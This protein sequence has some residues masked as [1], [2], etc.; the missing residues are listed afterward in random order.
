[1]NTTWVEK[2]IGG[3]Y[4]DMG[5]KL[6]VDP[7]IP[8]ILTNRGIPFGKME[9]FLYGEI[10]DLCSPHLMINLDK[11][12][13]VLK[14]KIDAGKKIRIIGDY[15]IDGV[16]SSY[17]LYAAIKRVGGNV[18]VLLP[19]RIH[20]GYGMNISMIEKAKADDVDTIITCDNGIAAID[21]CALA[22][23]Y[24]ICVLITD[25]HELMYHMENDVK[26]YDL[27][28]ADV[29]VDPKM[30]KDDIYHNLC[31]AAIC[32]KLSQVL[33]KNYGIEDLEEFLEYAAF[34]T[35]GDVMP[36][37]DENRLMVKYGL[38]ALANTKNP[39]L[40]SLIKQCGLKDAVDISVY[41]IGFVLGPCINAAGRMDDAIKAFDLL[42]S[43][44][45]SAQIMAAELVALNEQ[46]KSMTEEAVI[47]AKEKIEKG[48][49][50]NVLVIYL[51]NVHESLL[52][53]IAGRLKETYERPAIVLT[54][55]ANGI[56]GSAR[57]IE[58]YNIYEHLSEC[59]EMFS[60]FGGHALAAGLSIECSKEQIE[61][62]VKELSDFLNS[63]DGLG[64]EDFK[65]KIYIDS[66]IPFSYIS[67]KMVLDLKL[68]EP[69]GTGINKPVFANRGVKLFS[70][71]ILGKNGR[72]F[73]CVATD[74]SG[75]SI[76]ALFF[77]EPTEIEKITDVC[78]S[79]RE[80]SVLFY[81]QINEFRNTKTL[82][83]VI[84]DYK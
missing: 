64:E 27:P 42:N 14:E 11:L 33:Y 79:G 72:T 58:A 5:H 83:I 60:K 54:G 15:D 43:S 4:I 10:K 25:H 39:G 44:K 17:I 66:V 67:E 32:Y 38:Q 31:G 30:D 53:I 50:S 3:D 26:I 7:V 28:D 45:E 29:I 81:P 57:S 78:N 68:L 74:N 18:D 49:L 8:R 63:H 16:F 46:R 6:G 62:K 19:H 35:I 20:D 75:K 80:I 55:Y 82:Q 71:R 40:D 76:D 65:K 48:N 41:H 21:E 61:A 56:K 12:C 73:K 9:Y 36:L 77:G 51:P 52:G 59:R 23:K 84:T 22:R 1:M 37:L 47:L 2:R 24:G 70:G 69:M 34:A 13:G